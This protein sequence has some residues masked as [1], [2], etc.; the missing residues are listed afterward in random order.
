MA[1]KVSKSTFK[2][3]SEPADLERVSS[4]I[5]ELFTDLSDIIDRYLLSSL[6]QTLLAKTIHLQHLVLRRA[7]H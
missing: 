7:C 6:P 2:S 4:F 5:G 1:K 3:L